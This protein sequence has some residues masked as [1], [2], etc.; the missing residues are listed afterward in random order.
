MAPSNPFCPCFSPNSVFFFDWDKSE[1]TGTCLSKLIYLL[2][3]L[4]AKVC[5]R[6]FLYNILE[7]YVVR[8]CVVLL[9]WHG[10]YLF[11]VVLE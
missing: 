5:T 2:S 8:V 4:H 1:R 9:K 3:H 11:S 10:T 6:L 7:C